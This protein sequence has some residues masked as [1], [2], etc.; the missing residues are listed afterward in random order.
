MKNIITDKTVAEVGR[1]LAYREKKEKTSVS[2]SGEIIRAA[3]A[4][5]G[6]TQRS[7]L[8]ERALRAY[9]R[10][11]VNRSRN[12]R[13]LEAINASAKVTNRESDRVLELQA[14][15]E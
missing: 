11:L 4:V 2:L 15:P 1:L 8:I 10:R 3:D 5:A 14:W 13:D 7:A 9:L 12:E 6:K